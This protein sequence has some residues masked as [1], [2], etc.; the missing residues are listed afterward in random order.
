MVGRATCKTL[1][2]LKGKKVALQW[3]GPHVGMFDDVLRSVGLKWEDVKVVWTDDVTGP[4]GPAELF[5]KDP[6]IDAC[7]VVTP[8]MEALTGGLEKTGGGQETTVKGAKVLVSTVS[9]SHSIADVYACRKDYYDKNK[10]TI[11]KFVAAYLKACEELVEMRKNYDLKEKKNDE[12]LKNYKAVL[13]MTQDIY[14]K[15][16]LDKPEDA[17]GLISDATFVAL[18]GNYSFFKDEKN[19]VNFSNR[20]K[21]ALDMA[22]SQGYATKRID[23]IAA[24]LDYD[25]LKD[26]GKLKL[27]VK[28]K[29]TDV[30]PDDVKT[31][32]LIDP[33]KV[34]YSFTVL[35][36]PDGSRFDMKKYEGD[37]EKAI[38]A[39]ALYGN[40]LVAVRGHV[41]PTRTIR[42]FVLAGTKK[43]FITREKVGDGYKYYL[44]KDGKEFELSD[45]K[46]VLEMIDAMDFSDIAGEDN[47]KLTV[48]AAKAVWDMCAK[49]VREAIIALAKT[50]GM[51][52]DNSQLRSEGVGIKEPIITVPKN[53][54]QAAKNRRV[55]FQILKVSP[56]QLSKKDFDY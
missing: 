38:A 35:F 5:R 30:I 27:E 20:A 29:R 28:P 37:F 1:N 4:K 11:D 9:L 54:E 6:S 43:R 42:Q 34:I 46:K 15:T 14:G 55:E 45:T 18:P 24:D 25:K 3:G 22:V 23:L 41:D 16:L 8:D 51:T 10:A 32:K 52:L 56:E 44:A 13:K 40:A 12:L 21:A 7:F 48:R 26:L 17:H 47:P 33:D 50:K 19:P 36:D 49:N 2:D 53:E 31:E 39:A